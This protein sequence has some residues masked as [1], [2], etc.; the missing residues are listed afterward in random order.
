MSSAEV[1]FLRP[2]ADLDDP[3]NIETRQATYLDNQFR[4]LREDML[5]EMKEELPIALGK[6]RRRSRNPILEGFKLYSAHYEPL[7][8]NGSQSDRGNIRWGIVLEALRDLPQF[9]NPDIPKDKR[10]AFLKDNRNVLRHESMMCLLI[11]GD[12]IAFPRLI[13]DEDLLVLPK[14]RLVLR[15][16]G[17]ASTINALL[18]FKS[19]HK[20]VKLVQIDTAVFAY[21]PVLKSLQEMKSVPLSEE[22]LFWKDGDKLAET[23]L[24]PTRLVNVLQRQP[25]ADLQSLLDTQKSI[26]LDKSQAASLLLGLTQKVSLI[27]G[28]PGKFIILY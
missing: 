4:M 20:E 25:T 8:V 22:L 6:K 1:S 2:S 12:V 18:R 24:Q 28:P 3:H 5:Y 9:H 15:L 16:D 13:R 21:E 11:D 26:K 10:K 7:P 14:A 23:T 17:E 19:P 27:Q